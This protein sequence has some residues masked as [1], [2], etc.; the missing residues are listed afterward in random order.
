[1]NSIFPVVGRTDLAIPVY[2]G[3]KSLEPYN[4]REIIRDYYLK[5][6]L[7]WIM[8]SEHATDK[9]MISVKSESPWHTA[10]GVEDLITAR[11]VYLE[12]GEIEFVKCID[13]AISEGIVWLTEQAEFDNNGSVCSW[14]NLLYDT[15]KVV[16]T[17]VVFKNDFAG[18]KDV[19]LTGKVQRCI[20]AG[21][22]WLCIRL[23][24]SE[25]IAVDWSYEASVSSVL[26]MFLDL[27]K[28]DYEKLKRSE[29]DA[30]VI[31]SESRNYIR[32]LVKELISR[33]P[34]EEILETN[35][36]YVGITHL[37]SLT[38]TTKAFAKIVRIV[39]S[40]DDGDWL[41]KEIGEQEYETIKEILHKNFQALQ[42]KLANQYRKH[43]MVSLGLTAYIPAGKTMR[44]LSGI[45]SS[46]DIDDG[47]VL[48]NF[49]NLVIDGVVFKNGS[50][51]HDVETT[52]EFIHACLILCT[53]WEYAEKKIP[54]V[55]HEVLRDFNI[56]RKI[57]KE[58]G[59]QAK[60]RKE[61]ITLRDTVQRKEEEYRNLK[62]EKRKM[63]IY[64]ICFGVLA[65]VSV[66]LAILYMAGK[67]NI[68]LVGTHTI[69]ITLTVST[70]I[71]TQ[72]FPKSASTS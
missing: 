10:D 70:F 20:D 23:S 43:V 11:S 47:L 51:Y 4:I 24:I 19:L 39:E 50:I 16:H 9:R 30:S 53:E 13:K 12:N 7:I 22:Q 36:K 45:T 54:A 14:E 1:M 5:K 56:E 55:L 52:N 57:E 3:D 2:K 63:K 58:K 18:K 69:I 32:Q 60:L 59:K 29:T 41:K 31:W 8:Q 71:I 66:S 64:A 17:L 62:R 68:W 65:V 48:N 35:K 25:D 21:L 15:G 61:I 44:L 46:L 72:L 28:D 40:T 49:Y 42:I 37:T 33:N 34:T 6:A 38:S 26:K 67:S 27:S